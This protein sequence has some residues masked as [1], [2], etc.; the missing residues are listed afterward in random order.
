MSYFA[1]EIYW[2]DSIGYLTVYFKKIIIKSLSFIIPF[3]FSILFLSFWLYG[4]RM[5]RKSGIV[6]ILVWLLSIGAGVYGTLQ[7]K[8]FIWKVASNPTDTQT[9]YFT[10]TL[11]LYV[12]AAIIRLGLVL[13]AVL[14]AAC[15][16]R[17]DRR[18]KNKKP[19]L[20]VGR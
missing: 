14:F 17:P 9:P 20:E 7:W 15:S 4:L 10:S 1:T 16:Y 3:L 2:W 12:P 18:D 11:V 19:L 6:T 8:N 5:V 13:L